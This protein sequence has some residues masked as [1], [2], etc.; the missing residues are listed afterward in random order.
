MNSEQS[1]CI[2]FLCTICLSCALTS[3]LREGESLQKAC[4]DTQTSK[5]ANKQPRDMHACM[6]TS[7]GY[8]MKLKLQ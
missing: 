4:I 8:I 3:K 6:H 2:R 7:I 1:E 5:Q